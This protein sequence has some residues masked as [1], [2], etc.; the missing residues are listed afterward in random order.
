M[1]TLNDLL[2]FYRIRAWGNKLTSWRPIGYTLLGYL[3]AGRFEFLPIFFNSL[4]VFGTL[5]F[6]FSLN[7]YFDWKIQEED[8]F[9]AIQVQ[10]K[11]LTEKLALIYCFLPL[12]F[13]PFILFVYS[14][15]AIFLFL[16]F[17]LLVL[18]YSLPLIRLKQ[19]KLLGFL[20]S[21]L[22]AVI[23]FLQG[24]S[25][26]SYPYFSNLNIFLLAVIIFLFQC[27]LEILH[28]IKDSFD[29]NEIKEMNLER[30]L[31]LKWQFPLF[32]LFVSLI[33]SFFSPFFLITSLFS[34]V[35]MGMARKANIY[36]IP[37]MRANLFSPVLSLYEFGFYGV[38]GI[39][40][41]FH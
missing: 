25:V 7:D 19:K 13:L 22:G 12:L 6:S 15:T 5:A 23:L 1:L 8:N 24:Y 33:F 27:Y 17:F 21:P 4:A 38:L 34:I 35:R 30:A 11:K 18:F 28:I 3:M 10:Q 9:L 14:G 2:Y 29:M 32:S 37:K 36:N 20:A 40:H 31:K 39:F 26:L 16:T 41:L